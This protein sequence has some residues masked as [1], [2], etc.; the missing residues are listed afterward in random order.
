[1]AGFV[2]IAEILDGKHDEER[3]AIRGWVYNQRSSGG[4]QFLMMRDGTGVI[5]C[6]LNKGNVGDDTFNNVERLPM[7]SVL[8]LTGVVNVENRAPDGW[9]LSV[10]RVGNVIESQPNFPITR[11]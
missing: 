7:E 11:K 10:N 5:Q 4:I 9:E 8:E 6:T 2:D 1:M 3:I